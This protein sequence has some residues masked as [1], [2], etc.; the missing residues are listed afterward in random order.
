LTN[1]DYLI[2]G[3]GAGGCV[4]ANRLSEDPRISVLLLEAGGAD[5]NPFQRAE[6]FGQALRR[7]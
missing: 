3:S 6:G 2:A 4:L 1:Y 7:R 5:R